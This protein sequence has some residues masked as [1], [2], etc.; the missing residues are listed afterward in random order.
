MPASSKTL[1]NYDTRTPPAKNVL[2]IITKI[3]T[4]NY[5]G[6]TYHLAKFYPDVIRVLFLHMH[7][8]APQNN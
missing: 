3:C 4:G 1:Q 5:V 2:T 6:D 7:E 8:C